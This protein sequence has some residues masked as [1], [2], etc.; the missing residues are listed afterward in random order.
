MASEVLE[1]E[2]KYVSESENVVEK[3][4]K[5]LQVRFLKLKFIIFLGIYFV[6]T[7]SLI[8]SVSVYTK[9]GRSEL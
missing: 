1:K 7:G 4:L 9:Q 8:F 2:L 6:K 5:V 3:R